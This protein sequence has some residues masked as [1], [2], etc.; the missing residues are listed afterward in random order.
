VQ[1]RVDTGGGAAPAGLQLDLGDPGTS[2]ADSATAPAPA[3]SAAAAAGMPAIVTRAQWGADESLRDPTFKYT[4][5]VKIAV[6]HHTA[7]GNSYWQTGGDTLAAAAKD[8]RAIYAYSVATGYADVPYNFLVD[9]AGRIYEG[10]AGGVDK[11][12]LSAAT[13]GF[14]TDTMSIS[15]LGNF[16]IARPSASLVAGI[17]RI[18]AWKLGLFHRD[19][20][21]TTA[22]ISAGGGTDR[23][24]VGASV[25]LNNISGHRDTGATACPGSYLYPFLPAIRTA[26]KTLQQSAFYDPVVS[27]TVVPTPLT[28]P[29]TLTTR[30]SAAMS[31]QLQVADSTGHAVR[32]YT[33]SVPAA[34]TL[35][36]AWDLNDGAG[37]RVPDDYYTMTLTGSAA[38]GPPQP[39][40]T[41]VQFGS[42]DV[43]TAPPIGVQLWQPGYHTIAGVQWYQVRVPEPAAAALQR[44]RVRAVLGG[45]GRDVRVRQ[46]LGRVHD[47]VRRLRHAGVQHDAHVQTG[48]DRLRR[49]ALA[50]AVPAGREQRAADLLGVP[51]GE[52]G[53]PGVR[54]RVGVQVRDRPEV[55]VQGAHLAVGPPD[56]T[57]HA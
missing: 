55:A 45:Q 28:T 32:T 10:R 52:P 24:P 5:T 56:P 18:A 38:A 33:G 27:P 39:F 49:F 19:P 21:G 51:L 3:S 50:D 30:T 41:R 48:A 31:Y 22:L 12:V 57:T 46:G 42:P 6:V 35:S 20:T 25:T 1:V 15:A 7:S 29:M 26:A 13:G 40:T 11:A 23:W 47:D 14:N 54:D 43:P 2:P 37:H 9:Q 17:E 34:Q 8:L 36:I 44:A 53:G 16:Q 4:S